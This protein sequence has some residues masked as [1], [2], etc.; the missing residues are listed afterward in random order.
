MYD[1]DQ[2][3]GLIKQSFRTDA[4]AASASADL[5]VTVRSRL[6]RRR[7]VAASAT[8]VAVAVAAAQ[9]AGISDTKP[10]TKPF[11]LTGYT[12]QVRAD[13]RTGSTCLEDP[14][15]WARS[16]SP[17]GARRLVMVG[18][19]PVLADGTYVDCAAAAVTYTT[20]PSPIDTTTTPDGQTVYIV[21]SAGDTRVAYVALSTHESEH[22]ANLIGGPT[23]VP[24]SVIGEMPSD[25]D[26]SVLNSV[27]QRSQ[28]ILAGR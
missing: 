20:M 11:R 16:W 9:L 10:R 17:I 24:Y 13:A 21:D 3:I 1:D 22:G 18:L 4:D 14:S 19:R 7:V 27:L 12:F 15:R 8:A 26:Q 5:A 25:N 28:Q 2:I 23:S 6:T